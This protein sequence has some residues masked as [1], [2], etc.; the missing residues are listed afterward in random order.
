MSE[1]YK[2]NI[3]LITC[4]N[5]NLAKEI[6]NAPISNNYDAVLSK[7]GLPTI[8]ITQP[9]RDCYCHSPYDPLVEAKKYLRHFYEQHRSEL[10]KATSGIIIG[11]GL[12]YY[13][14]EVLS[15]YI[16]LDEI[17][18]I[19]PDVGLFKLALHC[20]D[21]SVLFARPNVHFVVG[22]L[23]PLKLKALD[24]ASN[25]Y[26]AQGIII[27]H[28]QIAT[29]AGPEYVMGVLKEITNYITRKDHITNLLEMKSKDIVKNNLYAFTHLFDKPLVNELFK[30]FP[31]IPVICVSSGP[32][33]TNYIA[34]LKAI[35]DQAIFI[36][37][38]SAFN[39]LIENGIVP[40]IVTAIEPQFCNKYDYIEKNAHLTKDILLV[41]TLDTYSGISKHWQGPAR[42]LLHRGLMKEMRELVPKLIDPGIEIFPGIP[43]VGLMSLIVA[44]K[45]GGNPIIM[46]GQDLRLT[47]VTHAAGSANARKIEIINENDQ[48]F[49]KVIKKTDEKDLVYDRQK[50][51]YL[52]DYDGKL[53][54]TTAALKHFKETIEGYIASTQAKI[55]NVTVGGVKIEGAPRST[56]E[57]IKPYLGNR[58]ERRLL[59][60]D[61][62][63]LFLRNNY[64]VNEW[65]KT[66]DTQS[67]GMKKDLDTGLDS[68]KKVD[69]NIEKR[70]IYLQELITSLDKKYPDFMSLLTFF[71]FKELETLKISKARY[72][73]HL[74]KYRS[75]M[76]KTVTLRRGLKKVRE[77]MIQA[78]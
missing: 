43:T 28:P 35:R 72:R 73:T 2:N 64:H 20:V 68:L 53:V 25:L 51:E 41:T 5:T 62:G 33:L 76:K 17:I 47:D 48:S 74:N 8:K 65:L 29:M 70:T 40:D 11:F 39:V 44:D 34:E 19:E 1:V 7:S 32:S 46:V 6:D 18:I 38:D 14:Q 3:Q 21:F 23:D 52:P 16:W 4:K 27:P 63:K 77:I 12:G 66:L 36:A 13:V 50:V 58:V 75:V 61:S 49:L 71:L 56:I 57:E 67:E 60:T 69:N 59:F 22:A 54:P 42:L 15:Q 9:G 24:E 30:K 37:V 45:F 26:S 55:M 31:A 78:L 10:D